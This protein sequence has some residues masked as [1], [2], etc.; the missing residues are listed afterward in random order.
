MLPR[1]VMVL[2]H[3]IRVTRVAGLRDYDGVRVDGL[4]NHEDRWIK[5]DAALGPRK[6][7]Q[8]LFHEILHVTLRL[9]GHDEMLQE[10]HEEALVCCLEHSLFHLVDISK[11]T[12]SSK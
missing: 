1:H 4:S 12:Q 10:R 6:A 3:K 11:L 9:S 2:G 7:Q 5:V 8:T